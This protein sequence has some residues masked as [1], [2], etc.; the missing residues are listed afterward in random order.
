MKH[1]C[2]IRMAIVMNRRRQ[3]SRQ[4]KATGR[5]FC[6]L[7]HGTL[8]VKTPALESRKKQ[9][10]KSSCTSLSPVVF[11]QFFQL[12]L[13]S[14]PAGRPVSGVYSQNHFPSSNIAKEM[15]GCIEWSWRP[16]DVII[17]A[18]DTLFGNLSQHCHLSQ[19]LGSVAG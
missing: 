11:N 12:A 18:D 10:L 1:F 3:A 16:L 5:E 4:M 7:M 14:F 8:S 17:F 13:W 6:I 19:S 15:S 2:S 9:H